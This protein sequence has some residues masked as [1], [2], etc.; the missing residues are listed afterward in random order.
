MVMTVH[1]SSRQRLAAHVIVMA[2]GERIAARASARAEVIALETFAPVTPWATPTRLTGAEGIQSLVRAQL[3][4]ERCACRQ[5]LPVSEFFHYAPATG[6]LERG[7]VDSARALLPASAASSLAE[8]ARDDARRGESQRR[9]SV[10]LVST[11]TL[12]DNVVLTI[13]HRDSNGTV[14]DVYGLV[15]DEQPTSEA[16]FSHSAI[17]P[18]ALES[19][20][21]LAH[22]DTLSLLVTAGGERFYGQI[23]STRS[24][25]AIVLPMGPLEGLT[26][27]VAL[28]TG[29]LGVPMVLTQTRLWHLGVLLLCTIVV[30]VIA[31]G[32]SRR[33]AALARARTDFIAGISHDLRMP[34]AQVLLASETLALRNDVGEPERAKLASSI[35]R[36][37]K[38]LIALVENVLLFSRSGAVELRAH[39]EPVAVDDLFDEVVDSV[40]LAVDDARQEITV[41]T[42]PGLA[43]LAD[44]R[45]V[46]QALVNLVDN[47]L[48]YGRI[49]QVIR[50]GA[51][52]LAAGSVALSV[53]DEGPGIPHQERSRLFEPYER[54]G[55]DQSSERTGTGLGLAVVKQIANACGGHVRLESTRGGGTRAVLALRAA[56]VPTAAERAAERV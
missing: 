21:S 55:R 17:R 34:L 43:V 9:P 32:S 26:L 12:R 2:T 23:D 33:E 37:A 45:L 39:L 8:I 4:S 15:A 46:R 56:T 11:P 20:I 50:L 7:T 14:V 48:K 29:Q 5:T 49:G 35:V 36:E 24:L 53:E 47:A 27:T 41:A 28:V 19:G 38:R 1:D 16:L 51:Q 31:V 22:Y 3:E 13:A 44:R 54:L 40:Q 30:I 6:A 18:G 10:H 25:R 52:P 42:A